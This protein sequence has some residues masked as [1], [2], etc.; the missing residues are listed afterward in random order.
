MK[1]ANRFRPAYRLSESGGLLLTRL[2]LPEHEN[3]HAEWLLRRNGTE[4]ESGMRVLLVESGEAMH[5]SLTVLEWIAVLA[6]FGSGP[7][8]VIAHYFWHRLE[9]AR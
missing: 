3:L 4:P 8:F 2:V 6:T 7:V 5:N 9:S 1:R